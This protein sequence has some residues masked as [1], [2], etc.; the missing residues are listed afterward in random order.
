MADRVLAFVCMVCPACAASRMWPRS[1][2]RRAVGAY[3]RFCPFCRA[4]RRLADASGGEEAG[5]KMA[6]GVVLML[7]AAAAAVAALAAAAAF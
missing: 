7:W 6:D 4:A 2:V 1:A 3:S 5:S